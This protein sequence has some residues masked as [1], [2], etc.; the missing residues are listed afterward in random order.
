M[1]S[2]SGPSA[3]ASA[4]DEEDE[5]VLEA[6]DVIL[7]G[8]TLYHEARLGVYSRREQNLSGRPTYQLR[9]QTGRSLSSSKVCQPSYMWY[10]D[11]WHV[12]DE[13]DLGLPTSHFFLRDPAQRPDL[14]FP[15]PPP[16]TG[17]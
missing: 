15:P 9:R 4:C 8:D 11:G 16:R 13:K 2:D 3:S 7:V 10:R 14:T 17:T 5:L 12:G 1:S 6:D